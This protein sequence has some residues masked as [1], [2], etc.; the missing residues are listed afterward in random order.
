MMHPRRVD[1]RRAFKYPEGRQ[2]R[3]NGIVSKELLANPD[4]RDG[5]NQPCLI[6]L[7]D[8]NSTDLTVGRATGMESFVRDDDTEEE[9][10]EIAIYNYDKSGGFSAQGDSGSLIVDGLGR[11]VGLLHAG[12]SKGGV[13]WADVT[14][15]TPIWWLC[16]EPDAGGR[17]NN[18][19]G[20]N[21]NRTKRERIG[22]K[23]VGL[24]TR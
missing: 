7:K 1:S 21:A 15:A 6:V 19:V 10:I 22:M 18:R 11:M 14:Y 13:E 24:K 17:G 12:T 2:L 8:G 5:N 9:S 20:V 4:L 23:W 3:I 16:I